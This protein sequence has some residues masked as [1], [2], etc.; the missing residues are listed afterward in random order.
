MSRNTQLAIYGFVPEEIN[1]VYEVARVKELNRSMQRPK[2]VKSKQ[3]LSNDE[4]G[5]GKNRHPSWLN[6]WMPQRCETGIQANGIPA[7]Y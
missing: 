7:K 4:G 3:F 5:M 1:S 6:W 2:T